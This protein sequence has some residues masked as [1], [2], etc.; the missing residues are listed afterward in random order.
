MK[1]IEKW[2]QTK[3]TF[4]E[5]ENNEINKLIDND[6]FCTDDIREFIMYYIY[7]ELEKNYPNK[8]DNEEIWEYTDMEVSNGLTAK[9]NYDRLIEYLTIY[10]TK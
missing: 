7:S 8:W 10:K 3:D 2:Y 9:E 5:Q 1:T 6:P 4:T